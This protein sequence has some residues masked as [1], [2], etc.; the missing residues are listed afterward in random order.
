MNSDIL[1][2]RNS[3]SYPKSQQMASK[4]VVH[5]T[6]YVAVTGDQESPKKMSF[7]TFVAA[8]SPEIPGLSGLTC[9]QISV[10]I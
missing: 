7:L 3:I 1:Y 6:H 10:T 5:S 8:A 2:A 9:L 4:L